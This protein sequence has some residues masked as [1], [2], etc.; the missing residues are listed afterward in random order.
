MSN[1]FITEFWDNYRQFM[2]NTFENTQE[3]LQH[4]SQKANSTSEQTTESGWASTQSWLHKETPSIQVNEQYVIVSFKLNQLVHKDNTQIFLE[5]NRLI[6]E[7]ALQSNLSLPVAVQ[8]YG[9]KA[10][11]RQGFLEIK[12]LKDRYVSRQLIPWE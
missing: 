9:A 3:L 8:K 2:Q 4:L 10:A 6:I 7:G 5:G 12:L 11:S 1:P